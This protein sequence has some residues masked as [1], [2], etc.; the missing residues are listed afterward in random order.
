M[1]TD[2][3]NRNITMTDLFISCITLFITA[4]LS[5]NRLERQ[6]YRYTTT[7][8]VH[9]RSQTSIEVCAAF[10]ILLILQHCI[11][12]CSNVI[13]NLKKNDCKPQKSLKTTC[14]QS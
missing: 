13:L 7:V 2:N 14:M 10:V 11:M 4:E 8:N 5:H 12:C 1:I 6:K 3:S 9:D